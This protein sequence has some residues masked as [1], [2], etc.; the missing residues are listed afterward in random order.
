[1]TTETPRERPAES[2]PAESAESA[3][4]AK[5]AA[6]RAS[7]RQWRQQAIETGQLRARVVNAITLAEARHDVFATR[8]LRQ[9]LA[10]LD[11]AILR[12]AA[13]VRR[14]E[15]DAW[16]MVDGWPESERTL[17]RDRMRFRK[18]QAAQQF[19]AQQTQTTAQA[20]RVESEPER[21]A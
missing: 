15:S 1:M 11:A 6:I 16:Q 18:R 14:L 13:D 12:F 10:D 3:T 20:T 8:R 4:D 9:Q 2:A 7:L 5:L 19:A 21:G 17:T